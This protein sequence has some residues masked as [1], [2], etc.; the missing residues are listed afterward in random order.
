MHAGWPM[1]DDMLA[2]L[3]T[4]PQLYV[5]LAAICFMIPKKEFYFYLERLVGAGF[6]KRIMFG[7]D[8]MIWPDAIE[9]GIKTINE[10]KFLT[11]GQKRDILFNNAVRFLR[12]PEKELKAMF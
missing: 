6:G 1:L 9:E 11:P 10:A 5:D 4:H 2:T 3:Y 8:N 7:S 12:I